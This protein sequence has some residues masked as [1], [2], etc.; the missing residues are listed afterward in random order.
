M[1]EKISILLV[2]DKPRNLIALEASLTCPEYNLVLADSG[3]AALRCLL[4]QDFAMILMDIQMPDMD[5][6]ETARHIQ[7]SEKTRCIPIIFMSA[8]HRSSEDIARGYQLQAIDYLIKPVDTGILKAKIAVLADLFRKTRQIQQQVLLLKK[9]EARLEETVHQRTI[10][11]IN[12]NAKLAR[13]LDRMELLVGIIR[14][15]GERQD[16]VSIFMAVLQNLESDVSIDWSM[17][18]ICTPGES[19][20][21]IAAIGNKRRDISESAGLK[22][23]GMISCDSF[24]G[25]WP[26]EHP[27]Y[28]STDSSPER[29]PLFLRLSEFG[30]TYILALPMVVGND[31]EGILLVGRLHAGFESGEIEFLRH[32]AAHLATA[33]RQRQLYA[34]V[35]D[36]YEALQSSLKSALQQ[37]RLR[38]MGQMASGIAHDIN[39]SLGPITVYSSML[40][41]REVGL[42]PQGRRFIETIQASADDIEHTVGRMRQF[43][44]KPEDNAA[45][46]PV[47]LNRI[48]EQVIDLTR[49]RWKNIPE[50]KGIV[51]DIQTDFQAD[52]PA[53]AGIDSELREALT[54]LVFNAVDAMPHGGVM[55]I[56]TGCVNH[57]VFLEI[58]D[59]GCG[60]DEATI[61][62]CLEPFFTTK[63]GQGTGLGLSM[64]HGILERHNGKLQIDSTSEKGTTIMLQFPILQDQ[65]APSRPAPLIQTVSDLHILCID[66][67]ARIRV[68]MADILEADGHRVTLA[69]DGRQGIAQF[70][71]SL[72]T[73]HP[74]D[75]VFT[76]L[77][78]PHMDG[79]MVAAVIKRLKPDTPI[80]LLT[81][82]GKTMNTGQEIP[83][84]IDRILSKPP[85]ITEIRRTLSELCGHCSAPKT[86]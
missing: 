61:A 50:Q 78:M 6:Y 22:T 2:D 19:R 4:Q 82:W 10:E 16:L 71:E 76:D 34:E 56:A 64:V 13:Q 48:C 73:G 45:M 29:L 80:I 5:G 39:N 36:A 57:H 59:S 75:V 77:G 85:D 17:I 14:T 66:D 47:E 18:L 74:F 70:R 68:A 58:T 55:R 40:L 41:E 23:D 62:R 83:E 54:N 79:R 69:D 51:I 72:E 11:M 21:K 28:F 52:L 46:Q 86:E 81:G 8:A 26:A 3:K 35:K 33:I 12:T 7:S 31:L 25:A 38:A 27:L 65:Q 42:S 30:L 49:P 1:T 67:E 84:H 60:M 24:G 9:S 32:T 43:Y 53:I 44:R 37:E 15:M 63:Q 20:M